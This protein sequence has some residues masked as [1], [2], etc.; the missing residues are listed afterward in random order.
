MDTTHTTDINEVIKAVANKKVVM[1]MTDD[2][3]F[4]VR[5]VLS[6]GTQV[7]VSKRGKE[8]IIDVERSMLF[9]YADPLR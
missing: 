6:N 1:V 4:K 7:R 2:D 5:E 9:M 3:T 8:S